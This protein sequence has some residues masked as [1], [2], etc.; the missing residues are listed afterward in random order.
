MN[1]ITDWMNRNPALARMAALPRPVLLGLGAAIVALFVVAALWMREPEY[2]ALFSNVEARDGGAIVSILNQRNVPYK[3][4]DNG[5]TIL[6]PADQVYALR[7]Q[8]AEQGLPRGGSVGFELLDEPKF[9]ASQFSEQITYQRAL[10]GELAR[11]IEALQP[12]KSARVHLAIPRQSLFVRERET[13]TASVLL[14]LYPS[15][16]LSESQ[17]SAIAWLVS[18]SVPKLNA[19]SVSIVDQDGRLMSSPGGEAAMDGTRRNFINDIEQRTAQRILTLL[20]PIVGPG[21]VRAQVSAAVDFSQRE[22]TS[23]VYRPNETPGTAAIRSKQTSDSAQN[24]MQPPAGVPGALSNEPPTNATAAIQTAPATPPA[25]GAQGQ[26]GAP[27]AQQGAAARPA[28]GP[29]A[30]NG[31]PVA[32]GAAPRQGS[33]RND[34]TVNY[35]VDRTISHVKHELGT[36][37]RLSV[38]VVVNYRNKNGEPA[39]LESSEMDDINALVKQAMGYSADRGDTLSVVNSAFTNTEP[40]FKPWENPEYRGL[41]LQILKVLLVLA[42]LFFLWRSIVRPIVQGFANAQV[43][44]VKNEAHLETLREQRRQDE[45]RASEMNRY[46]EN[47][48]TARQLAE[49]DPRAVAMVLRSWM[50]PKNAKS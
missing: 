34:A 3:F 25:Q 24:G 47:L 13:P 39:P 45:L 23:E 6:V 18:S 44:R 31:T 42:V 5:A 1:P 15:R 20:N 11:S 26:T 17:V 37:Q 27:G 29:T 28:G 33:L 14:T 40:Q 7:L 2:R 46:E 35:E 19:E 4:A 21:N 43:E 9:G 36:L 8:L 38:A 12:V 22:Q 50:D 16:T 41:A 10:E 48:D 32:S 30:I 49:R